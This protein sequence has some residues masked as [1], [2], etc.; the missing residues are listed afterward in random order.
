MGAAFDWAINSPDPSTQN[1]AF[2]IYPDNNIALETLAV[3]EF[4][5]DVQQSDERWTRPTKYYFVEHAERNAIYRACRE[6]IKTEGMGLVSPWASCADCARAIIQAGITTLVRYHHD[7]AERWNASITAGDEMFE[8]AGVAIIT[9]RD[10]YPNVKPLRF[11][12]ELW[13]P[14]GV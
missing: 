13:T 4:P 11:N 1:S 3:N 10:P 12:G 7:T 14:Q 6:G 9:I 5:R 8:E 2:L